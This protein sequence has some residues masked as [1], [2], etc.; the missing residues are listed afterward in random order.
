M[1]HLAPDFAYIH[2]SEFYG[3]EYFEE[4]YAAADRATAGFRNV[5][6]DDLTTAL[7]TDPRILLVFR[8]ITGLTRGEFS[9]STS[10][11]AEPLDIEP[12]S[13]NKVDSMESRGTATTSEQASLI[14]KTLTMIMDGSLFATLLE[15]SS[16]NRRNQTR[17][18]AGIA[19]ENSPQPRSPSLSFCTSAITAGLSGKFLM[20]PPP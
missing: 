15:T 14:A 19:F 9:H 6:T 8:T 1:P 3:R 2:E 16:A 7:Q 13:V 12:I 17:N 10:L 5:S 4:V 20:R 11:A 18:R